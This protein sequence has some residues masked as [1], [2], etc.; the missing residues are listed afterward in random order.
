MKTRQYCIAMA[1]GAMAWS[2]VSFAQD[3][4]GH[5]PA[6]AEGIKGGSLPPPGVYLRDYNLFYYADRYHQ[7]GP[8]DFKVFLYAQAPRLIWITDVKILGGYYGMDVLLPFYSADVRVG[9][10][11]GRMSDDTFTLGDIMVEP[12]TL[13]WHWKQFD[14]GLGYAFWAP[15]GDY[16]EKDDFSRLLSRG[17]WSHM[18]TLG[19]TW[20][21]DEQKTWAVS[22]LNRYEFHHR[23]RDTHI[24]PGQQL[25]MEWG[26]SKAL[27]KTI[28][29][30]AV[31]YYVQQTTDDSGTGSGDRKDRVFAV[32]P[33]VSLFC[34]KLKLFGS[35]RYEREFGAKHRP[36]G[37]VMT[38]TLTKI[39]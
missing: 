27:T 36:E 16:D 30:G 9:T 7:G 5:Y 28:E 12:A 11:G 14:L 22:S 10:P 32:G 26:L 20:F 19:G 34:P 4:N 31:G 21:I 25:T 29:V 39:F 33:E 17:Y 23:H 37:N 13:S 2:T 15:N 8:P 24:T 3:Y 38:L 35:L 6:G 1:V 18:L